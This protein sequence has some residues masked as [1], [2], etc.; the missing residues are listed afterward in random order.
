[1]P[2]LLEVKRG[3]MLVSPHGFF[4]GS[5]PLFYEILA[6][7]ADLLP[8]LP[9][10]GAIVGDMHLENLGAYRR[11]D[12]AVTFDLNDFDEALP[13][14]PLA[15]DVLRLATSTLLSA[16]YLNASGPVLLELAGRL[17]GAHARALF[18]RGRVRDPPLPEVIAS[19]LHRLERRT[20]QEFL[21]QR[22]AGRPDRRTFVLDGQRYLPLPAALRRAFPPLL[23]N[24][25][26]RLERKGQNPLGEVHVEDVAFRVAGTG[27][28]GKLRIA[29]LVENGRRERL[30]DFKEAGLPA[31]LP[32]V[33]D[34]GLDQAERMVGVASR[35][36]PSLPRRMCAVRSAAL[37][38]SFVGQQLTPQKDKLDLTRIEAGER[39]DRLLETLG[40]I[41]GRAHARGARSLPRSAWDDRKLRGVLSRAAELAAIYEGIHLAYALSYGEVVVH[42]SAAP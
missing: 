18:S 8:D 21:A 39:L 25:A 32:L 5:A 23:S 36:L 40:H 16:R 33:P 4:R 9:G 37:D 30:L 29:A 1:M 6:T 22:T 12:G 14:A 13:D 19:M 20:Q 26:A 38:L 27:S 24:Y 35:L 3:K 15:L 17:L 28:L 11:N 31:E 34:P 7:R 42:G 10:S 2:R 41:V